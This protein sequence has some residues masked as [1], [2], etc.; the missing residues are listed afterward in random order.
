[1]RLTTKFI[2]EESIQTATILKLKV[3]QMDIIRKKA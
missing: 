1:M 3:L 2:L